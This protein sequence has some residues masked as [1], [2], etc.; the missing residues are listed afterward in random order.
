LKKVQVWRSS[1]GSGVG[2]GPAET[3]ALYWGCSVTE[4]HFEVARW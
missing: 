1:G 4:I 3:M 2:G